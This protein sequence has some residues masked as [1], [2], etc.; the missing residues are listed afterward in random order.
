MANI[1]T[2]EIDTGDLEIGPCE[3]EDG[4]I[5]FSGADLLVRG[6]ILARDSSTLKFRIF[7][8]GGSTNE[9]GIPKAV[10]AHDVEATGSGDLAVRAIVEGNVNQ[11]RLVIDADGDASNVTAAVR[12]K[13]RDYKITCSEVTQLDGAIFTDEDS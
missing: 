4:L 6:T 11:D 12:D 1:V 10:L 5:N 8:V 7:V 13:L 9:N 3:Y 2:T